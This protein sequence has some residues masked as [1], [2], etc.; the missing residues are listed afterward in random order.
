M[1]DPQL[2][3][4]TL[5]GIRTAYKGKMCINLDLDRQMYAFCTPEDI[6]QQVRT[7]V[8]TLNLPHGGLMVSGS[9]HGDN[10]PLKN[11]KALC[12]ACESICLAD[13]Q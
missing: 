3:A 5:E 8:E 2:R 10:V 13:K 7:S 12:A 6:W 11:I 1:H 4:N 9:V